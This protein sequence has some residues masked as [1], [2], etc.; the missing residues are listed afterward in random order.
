MNYEDNYPH[1]TKTTIN[2]SVLN[3]FDPVTCNITYIEGYCRATALFVS[4][5]YVNKS[6]F[7]FVYMDQF[8]LTKIIIYNLCN[9][10]LYITYS[11]TFSISDEREFSYFKTRKYFF[12]QAI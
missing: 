11:N 8:V 10:I 5:S 3:S 12:I 7:V 9:S 4:S 2:F 6:T 1:T